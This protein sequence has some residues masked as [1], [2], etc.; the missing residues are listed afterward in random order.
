VTLALKARAGIHA[1]ARSIL[2]VA[3]FVAVAALFLQPFCA[4]GFTPVTHLE[5]A[6]PAASGCHEPVPATPNPPGPDHVCCNGDHSS[7][8]LLTAAYITALPV[9]S[10]IPQIPAFGLAIPDRLFAATV[11][12]SSGPPVPFALRI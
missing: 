11:S 4:M 5:S 1:M 10:Q 9:V 6:V 12:P 3:A 8:A 7:D 2:R